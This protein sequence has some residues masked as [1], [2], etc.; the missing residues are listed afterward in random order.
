MLISPRRIFRISGSSS[1]D[2]ERRRC[3]NLVS[4][5]LS[6]S[7]EH[8]SELQSR[9]YVVCRLLLEKKTNAPAT[10]STSAFTSSLGAHSMEICQVVLFLPYL[11]CTVWIRLT[12]SAAVP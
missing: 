4:R 2:V 10:S 11:S 7:E 6:R 5:S 8:T 9:Q 12:G 1:S 3:P